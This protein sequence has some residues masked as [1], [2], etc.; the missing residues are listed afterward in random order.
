MGQSGFTVGSRRIRRGSGPLLLGVVLVA[1]L[2]GCSILGIDPGQYD[3]IKALVKEVDFGAAG[4][5][6]HETY[7]GGGLAGG[8]AYEAFVVGSNSFDAIETQ[9]VKVGFH[10]DKSGGCRRV[11]HGEVAVY[12][13]PYSRGDSF[14]DP[15]GK[16]IK[17]GSAGTLVGLAT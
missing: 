13:S 3:K 10:C 14:T 4:T 2:T 9:L 12:L 17:A 6:T 15:S 7:Y 11:E 1:L 8:P 5:V 16:T